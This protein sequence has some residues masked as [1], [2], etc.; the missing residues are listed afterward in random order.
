MGFKKVHNRPKESQWSTVPASTNWVSFF[1]WSFSVSSECGTCKR[2][3]DVPTNTRSGPKRFKTIWPRSLQRWSGVNQMFRPSTRPNET[4]HL[5]GNESKTM[6]S[7]S[8][9]RTKSKWIPVPVLIWTVNRL[10]QLMGV[11]FAW[12]SAFSDQN[13][14]YITQLW[15]WFWFQHFIFHYFFI[16]FIY[17]ISFQ[18]NALTPTRIIYNMYP[19]RVP[20]TFSLCGTIPLRT[21]VYGMWCGRYYNFS[22]IFEPHERHMFF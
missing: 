21:N 13:I 12:I 19:V 17:P 22:Q 9:A 3:H 16:L 6:S 20:C 11:Y 14:L 10:V 18:F 1:G 7:C 5:S 2:L 15:L 8:G 4:K